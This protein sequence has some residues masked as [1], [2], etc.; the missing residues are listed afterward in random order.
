MADNRRDEERLA[1]LAPPESS[2]IAGN[3]GV[4]IADLSGIPH[5]G[6]EDWVGVNDRAQRG[7]LSTTGSS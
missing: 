5:L 6:E 3:N 4:P 1:E 7:W 2:P